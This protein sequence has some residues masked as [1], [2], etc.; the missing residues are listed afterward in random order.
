[1]VIL[2]FIGIW[3]DCSSLVVAPVGKL[4]VLCGIEIEI[5]VYFLLI[6]KIIVECMVSELGS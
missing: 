6:K 2:T 3:T 4:E 1:M 5:E